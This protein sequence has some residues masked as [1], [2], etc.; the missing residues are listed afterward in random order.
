VRRS[1]RQVRTMTETE[2]W[3]AWALIL[4]AFAYLY[5]RSAWILWARFTR[6]RQVKRW[7]TMMPY[8]A[9]VMPDGTTFQ[10]RSQT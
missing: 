2:V 8:N 6:R 9:V 10:Y 4:L 5:G 7:S 3:I 1:Y